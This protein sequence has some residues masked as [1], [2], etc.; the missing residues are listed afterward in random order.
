M[1]TAGWTHHRYNLMSVINVMDAL[2]VD[3][4]R[5]SHGLTHPC[6]IIINGYVC[7][8]ISYTQHIRTAG[9]TH[10]RYH[11]MSVIRV[12]DAVCVD[13]MR[14]LHCLLH[15]CQIIMNGYVCVAINYTQDMRTAGWTH[16]RYHLVSMIR[17]MVRCA[18]IRCAARIACCTLAILQ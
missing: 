2:C 10:H 1:R 14:S 12:M 9:W 11:F 18:L 5:S 8:A 4:M 15:P 6:Q 7:V 3:A 13:A 17:V 16:H